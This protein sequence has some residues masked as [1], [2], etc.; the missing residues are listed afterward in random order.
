MAVQ[1]VVGLALDAGNRQT[2]DR[3]LLA[4][5]GIS[6][7]LDLEKWVRYAGEAGSASGRSRPHSEDEYGEIPS[8]VERILADGDLQKKGR[9]RSGIDCMPSA[10]KR[11]MVQLPGEFLH[12]Q[13]G[14]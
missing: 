13:A 4:S 3:N 6:S 1:A 7:V 12:A 10:S 5:Q 14:S 8:G 2:G 9:I 11:R